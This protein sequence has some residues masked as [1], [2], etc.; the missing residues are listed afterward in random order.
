MDELHGQVVSLRAVKTR[1]ALIRH[2]DTKLREVSERVQ[3]ATMEIV[4]REQKLMLARIQFQ[5]SLSEI[6]R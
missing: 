2:L 5:D 4:D 1:G 3:T 6:K